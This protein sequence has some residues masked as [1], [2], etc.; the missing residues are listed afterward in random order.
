[1][2]N[3]SDAK[4][5]LNIRS[6]AGKM[7]KPL[8]ILLTNNKS[9]AGFILLASLIIFGILGQFFTPYNPNKYEFTGGM[10]PS[11]AHILGTTVYGQDVFSQLF[12]GAA[13]TLMV[14][15]AVGIIG[16]SI[17]IAVGISAGFASERVNAFITGIINIFLIIPGVLLIMLFGSFF[18]GIHKSLGY[19]P[20]ILILIITGW[21]FGAR[22]FRSITLSI[23]KRD[24]IL[25]SVL[26]G[27][28]R[29][30]II[31]R[32]IIR[33]IFPVIISN[34]FFTAMYG[35][36]GLTFVEYLGVGNLLQINWGTMLYWA[37]NNEAY[38]TGM[39][40]WILP[41]SFMISILMF[42]FIL[43]NFG[44]DEIGNPSLRRFDSKK[45]KK[46]KKIS[47]D[48]NVDTEN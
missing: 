8:K 29:L 40:W 18:L 23:A 17:S 6:I 22:T 14:G 27:E 16:T 15:L 25:S 44:M 45:S 20:T 9:K 26:I 32:Q 11:Y 13:P 38:L 5:P 2:E 10:A 34:F 7:V 12:Y 1:M 28:S 35:T 42:S 48:L 21:A 31:F 30:S 47:D 19:L 46:N 43:L 3:Q 4:K 39:W 24:F 37:I 36:M 33:A 41:P